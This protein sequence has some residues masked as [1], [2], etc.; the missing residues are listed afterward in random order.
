M[1]SRR[2]MDFVPKSTAKKPSTVVK[3][4]EEVEVTDFEVNEIFEERNKNVRAGVTV[5]SGKT[6]KVE[7]YQKKFVKAE[8]PKRPLSEKEQEV[9]RAGQGIRGSE[10]GVKKVEK[11]RPTV[12]PTMVKKP[13]APAVVKKPVAPAVMK[14]PVAK[15]SKAEMVK[16]PE[17]L[18]PNPAFVNTE[19]VAKRPLSK[20][21]AKKKEVVPNETP[22]G[23]VT[24]ID[25]PKSDSKVGLIIT[26]I[27]TIILGAAAGTVAFLL[28]P[29]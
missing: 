8:V 17:A 21:V 11:K 23:P 20:S 9:K 26:I 15:V 12:A 14:K 25:K 13:V 5:P 7:D 24:I 1:S 29:K 4:T 19:K 27:I 6:P 28:L 16:K 2:Y 22:S 18:Q 3:K 10:Q